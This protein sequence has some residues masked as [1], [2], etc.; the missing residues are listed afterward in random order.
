MTIT[1]E[2]PSP[3]WPAD[4]AALRQAVMRAAPPGAVI[5]HIGSTAV[6]GLVAKDVIDIQLTVDKLTNVN[7]AALEAQGF[8]ERLGRQL[9]HLPPQLDLPEADLRKRFFRS[10][11][12]PANL[13]VR[14]QGR[15]NQRFPLLCRD[16]LRAHPTA[17]GAYGLIKQQLAQRF[18][19]DM[20]AYYDIKDP[21]FDIIIDGAN[22][23]AKLVGWSLPPG[24]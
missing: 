3:A 18:A 16:F 12:R 7:G 14:E 20:E 17:A 11:G 2:P 15:F 24:D 19:N 9:D 5:H 10:T 22:D 4:F 23:W 13:H 21:V 1:I 8:T 6:P